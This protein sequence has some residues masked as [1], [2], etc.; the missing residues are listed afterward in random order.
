[1]SRILAIAAITC[2]VTMLA[3]ACSNTTETQAE[4]EKLTQEERDKFQDYLKARERMA[5]AGDEKLTKKLRSLVGSLHINEQAYRA[6]E[7]VFDPNGAGFAPPT[8][9]V[10]KV[11]IAPDKLSFTAT[12]KH[13]E[14]GKCASI[15]TNDGSGDR[16]DTCALQ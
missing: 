14:S 4:W 12:V 7:D 1:M 5:K 6:T 2:L 9:F 15:T 11:K 16:T 8:G 13:L 10:Y 3:P